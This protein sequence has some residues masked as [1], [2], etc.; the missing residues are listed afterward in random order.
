MG[1]IRKKISNSAI[2]IEKIIYSLVRPITIVIID[3]V[4]ILILMILP[5]I[6]TLLNT[7][8]FSKISANQM[9]AYIG[10]MSTTFCTL[11]LSFATFWYAVNTKRENDKL[12]KKVVLNANMYE[13]IV[14]GESKSKI[15]IEI[16]IKVISDYIYSVITYDVLNI[17]IA[18][19]RLRKTFY[20]DVDLVQRHI[21]KNTS[22]PNLLLELTQDEIEDANFM[23]YVKINL[24]VNAINEGIETKN[25]LIITAE[26]TDIHE[27]YF[28]IIKDY[29][30]WSI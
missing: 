21:D 20:K 16:P 15:T 29:Q 2:N 28:K 5:F 19:G 1:S 9:L 7:G 22:T 8:Y 11:N 13:D 26:R 25:E 17:K 14:I 23:K 6:L 10:S 27:P 18:S 12:K 24:V 3:I 30:L 4:Y